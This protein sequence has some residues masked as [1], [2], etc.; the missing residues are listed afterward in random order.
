MVGT[1][2]KD[3]QP[4]DLQRCLDVVHESSQALLEM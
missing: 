4:E 1:L 2:D 3:V